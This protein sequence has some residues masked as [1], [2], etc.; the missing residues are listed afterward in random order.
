MNAKGEKQMSGLMTTGLFLALVGILVV[1]WGVTLHP[2]NLSSPD[3]M[4]F[5]TG[6]LI[7]FAIG[8]CMLSNLP[9]ICHLAS[10][11]L[12]AMATMVYIYSLPDTPLMIKLIGFVPVIALAIWLSLKFWK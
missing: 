4:S 2:I 5:A 11:W 7:L 10:I 3:F 12:A 6:G 8:L 9:S 1:I